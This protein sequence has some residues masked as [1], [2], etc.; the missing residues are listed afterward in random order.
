MKNIALAIL[1][2]GFMYIALTVEGI[3][4]MTLMLGIWSF[5]AAA[6]TFLV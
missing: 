2:V 1:A 4:G 6:A 3:G 5:I